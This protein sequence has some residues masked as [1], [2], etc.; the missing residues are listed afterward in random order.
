MTIPKTDLI[1]KKWPEVNELCEKKKIILW[2]RSQD[3]VHK[4]IPHLLHKPAYIV[5]SNPLYWNT[6]YCDLKVYNPKKLKQEKNFYIIITAGPYQSIVSNLKYRPGKDYCCTPAFYDFKILSELKPKK[7]I[8][9]VQD[10]D[11]KNH[12]RSS[13]MGGGIYHYDNGLKRLVKGQYRALKK[14]NDRYYAIEFARREIHI[15]SKNLQL[16][17]KIRLKITSLCGLA[18][19]N[20]DFYISSPAVDKVYVYDKNFDLKNEIALPN[21]GQHHINDI[22]VQDGF[23]YMS[24]FSISGNWKRGIFDGGI[25]S[26]DLNSGNRT[27]PVKDLWLPHSIDFMDNSL[28]YLDTMRGVLWKDNQQLGRFQGFMRGL[29]YDGRFYYIGQSVDL[30]SSVRYKLADNIMLTAGVY[31][32]DAE[33]KTSKF[34]AFPGFTNIYS[35]MVVG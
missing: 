19:Y 2:G 5:D 15:L 34:I 10:Y 9:T 18:H 17:K 35:V 23:L 20:G 6:T 32:F 4:T 33:T 22:H 14:V 25:I 8:I 29:A 16:E 3:W 26:H 30:Y 1:W 21:P 31:I 12:Y 24:C 28:V 7:F 27:Y 13:K 11:T